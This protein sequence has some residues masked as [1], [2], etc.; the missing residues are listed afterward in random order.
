MKKIVFLMTLIF[1][2]MGMTQF[3]LT[4]DGFRTEGGQDFYVKEISGKSK[5]DLFMSTYKS[6]RALYNNATDDIVR[7]STE[8]V[9]ITSVA[10][11]AVAINVG[12][13]LN[14]DL[15]Y[16]LSFEFKDEKIKVNAP[17]IIKIED[18]GGDLIYLNRDIKKEEGGRI[19]KGRS[20]FAGDNLKMSNV[21][22]DLEK[23]I[24]EKVNAVLKKAQDDATGW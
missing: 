1:P 9:S 4:P 13:K 6:V 2:L 18:K 8:I 21:K 12:I 7:D 16:K 3:V 23:V 24:N 14:Y 22:N 11:K 19:F 17:V 20:V 15:T 10:K 5:D